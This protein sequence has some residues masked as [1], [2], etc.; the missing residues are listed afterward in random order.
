[1]VEFISCFI[2]ISVGYCLGF[3]FGWIDGE[4][5]RYRK[6][7]TSPASSKKKSTLCQ[8]YSHLKKKAMAERLSEISLAYMPSQNIYEKVYDAEVV[9]DEIRINKA[10]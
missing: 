6:R 5:S 2:L 9:E 10:V 3:V 7:A 4:K 1:M 8:D